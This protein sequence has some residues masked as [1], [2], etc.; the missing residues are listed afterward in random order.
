MTAGLAAALVIVLASAGAG[1]APER[2]PEPTL[3]PGVVLTFPVED[4]VG[5]IEDYTLPDP[6]AVDG[7]VGDLVFPEASNDGAVED[8]GAGRQFLLSSDVLFAFDSAELSP[9][10]VSELADIAGKLKAAGVAE[11]TVVGHTDNQGAPPYNADLSQRRANAVQKALSDALGPGVNATATGRGEAEPV[12]DNL[13]PEGQALN[14]R[15]TISS[16]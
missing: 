10:A 15:V 9:R 3:P 16:R 6:V 8:L 11:I 4:V 5:Q 1:D 12:A 7:P 2:P 14:R 13:T